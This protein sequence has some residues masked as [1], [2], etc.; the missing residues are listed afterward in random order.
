M[1]NRWL[2]VTLLMLAG[3][4]AGAC[5]AGTV[6]IAA[7]VQ[8]GGR[9]VDRRDQKPY[10][11]KVAQ[12][13]PNKRQALAGA[14]REGHKHGTWTEWDAM[15]HKLKQARFKD[16]RLDGPWRAW[17]SN[18]KK[19]VEGTYSADLR[20]GTWTEWAEDGKQIYSGTYDAGRKHG[21]WAAWYTDGKQ[22][23]QGAYSEGKKH[24]TWTFWDKGGTMVKKEEYEKGKSLG[25]WTRAGGGGDQ[26]AEPSSMPGKEAPRAAK[27]KVRVVFHLMSQ[28]P[29]GVM[30]L[31]AFMPVV[32]ELGDQMSFR[33]EYIGEMRNGKPHSMH[34][35]NEV[36]GDIHQLCAQDLYP[37]LK[38]WTNFV[39]CENRT[40]RQLPAGWEKCARGAGMDVD[41]MRACINGSRGLELFKAS[42]QVSK[43]ANATGSPTMFIGGVEFKGER[44]KGE[45]M[46][47]ICAKLPHKP[48][49]CHKLPPPHVEPA[50]VATII[51]DKRCPK[52][53]KRIKEVDKIMK[54][55]FF[56]K[57][58]STYLDWSDARA[59]A[60]CKQLKIKMLP[61][62]LFH[63]G[64]DKA[65]KFKHLSRFLSKNGPY[66]Q[67]GGIGV[68]HD[69]LA[70]ICDNKKDDTGNGKVDCRDPSCKGKL[71]CRRER[72]RRVTL[73]IMSQCPFGVRAVNSMKEVLKNFGRRVKLEIHYI[74]EVKDGKPSSMHGQSEVDEN[75]RQLCAMKH[76]RKRNKY[77]DY[78]WCRNTG[79]DWRTND[80]KKCAVK[81][82]SA[83][84]IE[85]CFKGPG[86]KMLIRDFALA[87]KLQF[88]ASP[89]WL[90]NNKYKFTGIDAETIKTQICKHNKKLKNCNKTL[91][92]GSGAP[93]GGCG[94]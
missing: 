76:Y 43:D 58:T 13:H 24:G 52:C 81:G 86:T 19:K 59:K 36:Q 57:L 89:T 6:D 33:L 21:K 17:W 40:W 4:A 51:S 75:I 91:T 25:K 7:L 39:A 80:W 1:T 12:H 22:E 28:C 16:G 46:Q 68:A 45:F 71:T 5:G 88:G 74:G 94:N 65:K 18:G 72:K 23:E 11:G 66:W 77:L 73:F 78:I 60:L 87:K 67:L 47:K 92:K 85:R 84:V 50:V 42:I 35:D 32:R 2:K 41:R 3:A 26:P 55:R 63:Q 93:A 48:P 38:T 44:N 69:P 30:A 9:M 61:T 37:N 8:H 10:T 62:M 70:E 83:K 64:A 90:A 14:F 79:S 31:D 27:E 34:G 29:Y 53:D 82:I 49:A 54:G 20:Q 56:P 15:G